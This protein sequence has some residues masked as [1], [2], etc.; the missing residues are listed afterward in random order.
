MI[1][2]KDIQRV[3]RLLEYSQE[4]LNHCILATPTGTVR[5]NLTEANIHSMQMAD[6]LKA[7]IRES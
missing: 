4:E 1:K 6:K 5:E 2:T 7:A 3:L